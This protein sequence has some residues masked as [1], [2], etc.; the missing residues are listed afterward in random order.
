MAAFN[1]RI[2]FIYDLKVSGPFNYYV[3]LSE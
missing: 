2:I 1:E 3:N